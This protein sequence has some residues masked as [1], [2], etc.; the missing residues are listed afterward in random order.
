MDAQ[1]AYVYSFGGVDLSVFPDIDGWGHTELTWNMWGTAAYGLGTFVAGQ[2]FDKQF[3]FMVLQDW[4]PG[5]QET[6]RYLGKGAVMSNVGRR[7]K[8]GEAAG[9]TA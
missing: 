4:P 2:H 8:G 1:D 9:V 7:A 6:Q 3:Q 5:Q